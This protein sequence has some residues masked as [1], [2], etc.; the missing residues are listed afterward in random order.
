L[1]QAALNATRQIR[2][3]S[4]ADATIS[5]IAPVEIVASVRAIAANLY[6]IF[7]HPRVDKRCCGGAF[8]IDMG[9]RAVDSDGLRHKFRIEAFCDFFTYL[10]CFGADRGSDPRAQSMR[11][12]AQR[13]EL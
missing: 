8:E 12:C 1:E 13:F 5:S 9:P 2:K 10:E 6:M 7:R 4:A 3:M 11:R